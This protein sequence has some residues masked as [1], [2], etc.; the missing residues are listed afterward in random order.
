VLLHHSNLRLPAR[1]DRLLARVFITP[2]MHGIHHS[3]DPAQQSSNWSSGVTSLWDHLHHTFRH[4]APEA[5]IAIGV[6]GCTTPAQDRLLP[7]LWLP[8]APHPC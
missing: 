7:L 1:A 3:Q 6:Q 8:L 2:R 5:E 4:D